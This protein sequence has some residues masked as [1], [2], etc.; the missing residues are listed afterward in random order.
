MKASFI[1]KVAYITAI[2]LLLLPIAALSQPATVDPTRPDGGSP[3]GRLA[4]LRAKHN[5]AQAELG[6]I[7]PAS[8]T[9]KLSTLGLRGV[10]ANILWLQANHYKKV[11]DWD[12]LEMIVNQII[13]LQPNFV[14]VWDF[15]AHN[16]SYNVSVEFDDYRMRYQWVKKGIEFLI[17]GTHY[18]RDE[19]G[20]LSQIGWFTGQKVGR[21]DEQR[22]FRRL[23]RDDKDFHQVFRTNGVEVD[24]GQGQDGKPDNWLVARLWYNRAVDAHTFL[25]KPI[26]GRTPLLFYSG[27]PMALI[28]GAAAMQKDGYFF[29]APQQ[30]WNQAH[31]EWLSYG[32][33]EL[34][35]SAG[36]TVHLNDKEAID[37][38]IK[39]AQE[40][41]DQLCPGAREQ[42]R[43]EKLAKL[44]PEQRAAVEKSPAQRTADDYTLAYEADL[45]TKVQPRDFLDKVSRENRPAVRKLVDQ[46]EEDEQYS[47]QI[48]LNR[49]IVNFEY[50]RTRCEAERTDLAQKAQK[51]VYDAD[52]IFSTSGEK[53]NEARQLYES[54]WKG[55]AELFAQHPTLM[56]N[57]E[58]QDLVD[59]VGRYRDLL[60][61]LDEPFP[62]DFPLWDLMDKH[63]KGRQIH[64]Q[65][66]LLQGITT[67][68][69]QPKEQPKPDEKK[70]QAEKAS[71]T[72][73]ATKAP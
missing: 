31:D 16:L 21:A 62:T 34:P 36:F 5:I 7:D 24:Q 30:R 55:F 64:D 58:A 47:H 69:E 11:E 70:D 54:A 17:L 43:Q 6:E 48:N 44:T 50:W 45:A 56:D 10:A 35:T 1:R 15:Q 38:R 52:K 23:F 59:S 28:N 46:I 12:K 22:Q 26:R 29:E 41:L 3:G 65:V 25:G 73:T 18:N 60:G 19:P 13:R 67:P 57:A 53:L 49:R 51:D 72:T 8:E 63:E 71:E 37:Q 42:I 2:A 66:K 39:E 61:Q 14:E 40:E 33:R 27:G 9:M 20:L 68:S 32:R 4:Q